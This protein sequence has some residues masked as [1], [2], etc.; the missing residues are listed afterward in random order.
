M[1]NYIQYLLQPR[2]QVFYRDQLTYYG[3]E[4]LKEVWLKTPPQLDTRSGIISIGVK[5]PVKL[6]QHLKE[7]SI[8]V[9]QMLDLLRI[10]PHFYN[11]MEEVKT[12]LTALQEFCVE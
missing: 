6:Q 4:D 11:T 1:Q 2:I 12:F 9:T 3:V 7:R 8:I 5:D 10:S